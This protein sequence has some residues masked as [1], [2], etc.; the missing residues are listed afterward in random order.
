M[1]FTHHSAESFVVSIIID[2]MSQWK[3]VLPHFAREPKMLDG[4]GQPV[5]FPLTA[6]KI[7]NLG[8]YADWQLDGTLEG[9]GSGTNA[10]CC[11]ILADMHAVHRAKKEIPMHLRLQMDN[12]AKDNKNHTVLGLV[13]LLVQ[14]GVVMDAQVL[15]AGHVLHS[16]ALMA[17]RAKSREFVLGSVSSHSDR[18]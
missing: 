17:L 10:M 5:A 1:A 18:A 2:A 6:S 15:Q 7:H 16:A 8:I 14:T 3:T 12:C 11:T 9:P 4:K 13:A